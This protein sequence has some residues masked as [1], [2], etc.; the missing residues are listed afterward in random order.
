MRRAEFIHDALQASLQ[1]VRLR[2]ER[3]QPIEHAPLESEAGL[4]CLLVARPLPRAQ[5]AR[6][7]Q[8]QRQVAGTEWFHKWVNAYHTDVAVVWREM[9][10]TI[11]VTFV[12]CDKPLISAIKPTRIHSVAI[13]R[14]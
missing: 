8:Q 7:E 4:V 11:S 1:I 9:E 14:D 12:E 5:I 2:I 6:R 10:T 13:D 3:R